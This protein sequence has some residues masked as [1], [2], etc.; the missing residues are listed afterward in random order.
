MRISVAKTH[1]NPL[2]STAVANKSEDNPF[3]SSSKKI[4]SRLRLI[5]RESF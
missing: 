3:I 1:T 4:T 2:I 5:D